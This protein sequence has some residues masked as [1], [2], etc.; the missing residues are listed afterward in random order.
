MID[1]LVPLHLPLSSKGSHGVVGRSTGWCPRPWP[2]QTCH[3]HH[4]PGRQ[5]PGPW[6]GSTRIE[7]NKPP[8][9]PKK[10]NQIACSP[11]V[12]YRMFAAAYDSEFVPESK[13][14]SS[15]R[16]VFGLG[17]EKPRRQVARHCDRL[18][19]PDLAAAGRQDPTIA[20]RRLRE[21]FT[22]LGRKNERKRLASQLELKMRAIYYDVI[23]P[24]AVEGYIASIYDKVRGGRRGISLWA[25]RYVDTL[26]QSVP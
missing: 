12:F 9:H 16:T 18:F 24:A 5:F 8:P 11:Y 6:A 7:Q 23:D 14:I 19:P 4:I 10:T 13:K 26:I 3:Y 21:N 1:G 25:R 22:I 15:T 17:P 20:A 2:T